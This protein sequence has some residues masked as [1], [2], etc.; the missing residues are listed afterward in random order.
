M[1]DMKKVYDDLIIFNLY[2]YPINIK[3]DLQYL[4]KMICSSNLQQPWLGLKQIKIQRDFDCPFFKHQAYIPMK[5]F[6][7][8]D[9]HHKL[10]DSFCT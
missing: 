7:K 6:L 4:M 5:H 8:Q 9:F 3:R 10:T 1:A 2:Y